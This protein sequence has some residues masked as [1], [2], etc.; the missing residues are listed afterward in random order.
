M[1]AIRLGPAHL[2]RYRALMLEGYASHPDAFT[3]SAAERA[4]L[5]LDWWQARLK[6]EPSP[7][8]VA[9]GVELGGE[10]AGAVGVAFESR[11]KIRHKATLVG[12]YVR[13]HFRTLGV[14]AAL[15][16]AVLATARERPGVLLVQL[17]VSDHNVGA[18][19]LYRRHGFVE[20]G[21]EPMAMAAGAGYVAKC[22]M[23]CNLAAASASVA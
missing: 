11:E 13:E 18:K 6:D 1:N 8:V 19:R 9:L 17:T 15:V 16:A 23:W 10:L 2:E 7:S 14:G 5:P 20:F 3:S 12:L 4:A 22:H 21:V